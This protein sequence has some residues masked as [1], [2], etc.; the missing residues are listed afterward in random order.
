MPVLLGAIAA[1]R[2]FCIGSIHYDNAVLIGE[3][4]IAGQ[5]LD[6]TEGRRTRA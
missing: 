2:S 5:P 3:C 6:S 1:Y 4:G